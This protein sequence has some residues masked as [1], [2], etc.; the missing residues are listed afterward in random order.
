VTNE[1]SSEQSSE[2]SAVATSEA[3]ETVAEAAVEVAQIEAD[4]E[5]AIAE[6]E[7]ETHEAAIE[8]QSVVA[9]TDE[10]IEQCLKNIEAVASQTVVMA[11]QIA[12]I[13][14]RLETMQPPSP[15]EG[16]VS[17]ATRDSQ[18]APEPERRKKKSASWI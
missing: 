5:V 1:P 18:E 17:E 11:E 9:S 12:S 3:A 8:A 14:T 6:I 7:A 10:R 15:Q 13:Q 16:D 4:K 2:Q